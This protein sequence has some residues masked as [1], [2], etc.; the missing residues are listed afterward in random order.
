MHTGV[1]AGCVGAFPVDQQGGRQT[2]QQA[3]KSLELREQQ[4]R[5]MVLPVYP[6][7][8]SVVRLSVGCFGSQYT[9]T[10]SFS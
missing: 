2:G 3:A 9:Q 10:C 7:F 4:Q 8:R 1:C 5:A 6:C